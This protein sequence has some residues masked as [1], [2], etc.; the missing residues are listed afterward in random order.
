MAAEKT[1]FQKAIQE[2]LKE[3]EN[4]P[5]L[6]EANEK[7]SQDLAKK[8]SMHTCMC[9]IQKPIRLSDIKTSSRIHY[10]DNICKE[11]FTDDYKDLCTVVCLTCRKAVLRV[12]PHTTKS[13]FRFEKGKV[14]HTEACPMCHPNLKTSSII[15]Q[16]QYEK[17]KGWTSQTFSPNK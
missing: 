11:C 2:G 12:T 10:V 8:K 1:E 4:N 13:G 17:D 14:Y 15:E 16:L 6:R 7:F 3:I 9:G 5:V